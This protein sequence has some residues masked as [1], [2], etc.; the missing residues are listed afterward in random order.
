MRE[1]AENSSNRDTTEFIF[2]R[3][4]SSIFPQGVD[5]TKTVIMYDG[6]VF[7]HEVSD[8]AKEKEYENDS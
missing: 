8:Y 1:E 2:G 4:F 6:K 3:F 5:R 7:G